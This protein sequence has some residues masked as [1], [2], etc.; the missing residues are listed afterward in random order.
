LLHADKYYRRF[1]ENL[2]IGEEIKKEYK[3]APINGA[4][5]YTATTPA[6]R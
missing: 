4:F 3:K 6:I 5:N 1:G 2:N